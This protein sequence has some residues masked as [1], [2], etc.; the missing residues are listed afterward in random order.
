M[1]LTKVLSSHIWYLEHGWFIAWKNYWI[2]FI[3]SKFSRN[4]KLSNLWKLENTIFLILSKHTNFRRIR[5]WSTVYCESFRADNIFFPNTSDFCGLVDILRDRNTVYIPGP[6]SLNGQTSYCYISW[7]LEV[8]RFG[9]RLLFQSP[10]I[11]TGCTAAALL[12]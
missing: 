6:Y 7:S 12:I 8:A 11:F 9:F 1:G 3:C 5:K 2:M 4:H 10:W